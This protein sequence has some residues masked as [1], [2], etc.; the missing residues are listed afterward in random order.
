M[1]SCL[2]LTA[3][4]ADQFLQF[5]HV[6]RQRIEPGIEPLEAAR[7]LLN[8]RFEVFVLDAGDIH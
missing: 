1:M 6:T 2:C 5:G 4:G 3:A 8:S 7:V